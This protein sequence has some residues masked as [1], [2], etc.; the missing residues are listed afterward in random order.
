MGH[1]CR[2]RPAVYIQ[3]VL[4]TLVHEWGTNVKRGKEKSGAVLISQCTDT[5]WP[6][7]KQHQCTYRTYLWWLVTVSSKI[8]YKILCAVSNGWRHFLTLH[9]CDGNICVNGP[10]PDNDICCQW[11]CSHLPLGSSWPAGGD[12][13]MKTSSCLIKTRISTIP[14]PIPAILNWIPYW[15]HTLFLQF[16]Y[17]LTVFQNITHGAT[18]TG[19][20]D[21]GGGLCTGECAVS[22]LGENIN[23]TSMLTLCGCLTPHC[24]CIFQ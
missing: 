7:Q 12:A 15:C 22:K 4:Q 23:S 19:L 9:C 16:K 2:R 6:Q 10:V 8:R 13:T 24:T 5:V 18:L 21:L 11:A 3:A 20:L 14:K 1:L 17:V